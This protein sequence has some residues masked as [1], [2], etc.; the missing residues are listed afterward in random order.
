MPTLRRLADLALQEA[1]ALAPLAVVWWFAYLDEDRGAVI[2][3][4]RELFRVA[5]FAEMRESMAGPALAYAVW[6]RD[7]MIAEEM[8]SS[9]VPVDWTEP[10]GGGPVTYGIANPFP[11]G[12]AGITGNPG[13]MVPSR[14]PG[15]VKS[16]AIGGVPQPMQ[17][18]I[19][20]A[21]LAAAQAAGQ[22]TFNIGGA[23]VSI[24]G[25]PA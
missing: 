1:L 8:D 7:A 11:L 3:R 2:E 17:P 6:R 14:Q 25:G 9:V 10:G 21:Q 13:P 16:Q 20:A 23:N 12:T 24:Q 22:G 5:T 4:V 15:V 18:E 19:A